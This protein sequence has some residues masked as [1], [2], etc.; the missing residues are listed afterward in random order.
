MRVLTA[1]VG[2]MA[3]TGGLLYMLSAEP[4]GEGTETG[5]NDVT[6]ADAG[7]VSLAPQDPLSQPIPAIVMPEPD[8]VQAPEPVIVPE[9]QPEVA[10]VDPAPAP[11][12]IPAP[13]SG[14]L[15]DVVHELSLG[16]VRELRKPVEADA[17]S[18]E[19]A[20]A[21]APAA[22]AAPAP[23]PVIEPAPT[24][25]ARTYTVQIGDSLAGIAFRYYGTTAA[26]L[27]ILNANPDQL[28]NPSALRPGMVLTI[29]ET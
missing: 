7:G 29:P 22:I 15:S 6:R 2:F 28:P 19:I 14:P 21:P 3:A 18:V 5:L 4:D 12:P 25:A 27:N 8:V 10:A 11:E 16:I 17:D 9:P 20:A 13:G 1:A 26:Y 23:A 24:V